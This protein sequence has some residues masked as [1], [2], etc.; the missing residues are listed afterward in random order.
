MNAPTS[1]RL[2]GGVGPVSL[3]LVFCC[4]AFFFFYNFLSLCLHPPRI[5][6]F[7]KPFTVQKLFFLLTFVVCTGA[8]L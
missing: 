7:S 4:C 6:Y 3:H 5:H 2:L 1:A 8:W